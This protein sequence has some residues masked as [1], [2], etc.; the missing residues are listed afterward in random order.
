MRSQEQP[1]EQHEGEQE[2]QESFEEAEP[3]ATPQ[4]S[5]PCPPSS[6]TTP[7]SSGLQQRSQIAGL[8]PPPTPQSGTIGGFTGQSRLERPLS[9]GSGVGLINA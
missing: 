5:T 9:T 7:P 8:A 3:T 2:P 1:L 4:G 6:P